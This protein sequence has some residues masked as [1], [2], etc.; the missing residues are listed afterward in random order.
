LDGAKIL[1]NASKHHAMSW[2]YAERLEQQLRAEVQT[3]LARAAAG[4]GGAEDGRVDLPGELKRRE[5]RLAKIAEVKAEIQR[6]AAVRD[7]EE[8]AAYEAKG[9]ERAAKEQARGRKLGGKPPSAPVPGPRTNDQINFT[10]GESRIMP[11]AG[12]L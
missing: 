2:G 8:R 12:G 9:A 6:R 4:A 3:L 11:V 1:A 7:A 5:D 10:D